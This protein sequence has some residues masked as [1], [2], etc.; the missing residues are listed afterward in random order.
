M[1]GFSCMVA[2]LL[3]IVWQ[4]LPYLYLIHW[5]VLSVGSLVDMRRVLR[6][7]A[8]LVSLGDTLIIPVRTNASTVLLCA[9]RISC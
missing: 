8:F 7:V 6:L 5:D 2:N 3:F 9:L 1:I 4:V